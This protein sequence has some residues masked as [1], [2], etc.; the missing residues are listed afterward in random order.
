VGPRCLGDNSVGGYI[1]GY[2]LIIQ[3]VKGY[4]NEKR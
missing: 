2:V 1:G 3:Y 4:K